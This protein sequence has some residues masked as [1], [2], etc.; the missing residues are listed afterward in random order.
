MIKASQPQICVLH[1]NVF[2]LYLYLLLLTEIFKNPITKTVMMAAIPAPLEG[3]FPV[4]APPLCR[5]FFCECIVECRLCASSGNNKDVF[6]LPRS[7]GR[8]TSFPQR[9][10]HPFFSFRFVLFPLTL[11]SSCLPFPFCCADLWIRWSFKHFYLKRVTDA[12]TLSQACA[13]SPEKAVYLPCSPQM[14]YLPL[15]LLIQRK[16]RRRRF[17]SKPST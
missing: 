10:S 6:A 4:R 5:R 17:K 3:T 13:F 15:P 1:R 11:L 12:E 8:L 9:F 2:S 7:L 14:A 16:R